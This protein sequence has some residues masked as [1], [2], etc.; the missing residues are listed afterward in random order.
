SVTLIWLPVAPDATKVSV[1]PLTVMVL[2]TAKPDDSESVPAAPDSA[3]AP[4][5]GAGV[6][7]WLL[8]AFPIA[9]PSVLKKLSPA[10][11]ADAASSDVLASVEIAEF[12]AA[13]R[14]V[15]VAA[16]VVPI[17]K[18]P[19]GGGVAL[20][21]VSLM[22]S[23]EPSGRLKVKLIWSPGFGLPAVMSMP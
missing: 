10:A 22:D 11:T 14:L 19:V 9:V 23:V 7:A 15:T 21:A 16:G 13:F 2:P 6:A 3:V 12:S 8:T 18:L 5:I 4:V 1:V 20:D 17:A